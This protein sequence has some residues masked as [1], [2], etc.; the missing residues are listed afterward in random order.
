MH[1]AMRT[2]KL[3][4][5]LLAGLAVAGCRAPGPV[6]KTPTPE[7]F[8]VPPD[9]DPRYSRPLEYPK[10]LLNKPPVKPANPNGLNGI[11]GGSGAGGGPNMMPGAAF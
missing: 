2:G 7:E 6:L 10:E 1:L 5:W 4:L 3:C 11:K 8:T 9:D